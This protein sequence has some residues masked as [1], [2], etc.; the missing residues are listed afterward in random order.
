MKKF[1]ISVALLLLAFVASAQEVERT[2]YTFAHRGEQTLCL[3]LYATPQA[4]SLQPCLVYVFGG[5]FLAGSRAEPTVIEVYEYFARR[6]WK[7]A[8]IDYRLGLKPLVDNPEGDYGVLDIRRMLI[9]AVDMATEDV[10][11]ATAYLVANA[12]QLGVDSGRIVTLG[13]SAGAI[14]VSQAE[15]AICNGQEAA[16][17]LPEGW[18]YAGVISMAGAIL[19]RGRLEWK[20][21]P[22]PMMLFHG[23]ADS[24]VP[25]DKVSLFGVSLHGSEHIYRSLDR[26]DSPCWFYDVRNMGHSYSWRPMY[27]QRSEMEAF[28]ERMAFGGEQLVVRQVV[29]DRSIEPC[30][31]NFW[32]MD[33]MKSNF[34]P[35]NA[36]DPSQA[37]I[38]N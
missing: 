12:E 17:L 30:K 18:N 27:L 24:N 8:A 31:K 36:H 1:F 13:S 20:Q 25:Y 32:L 21:K 26:I 29:D 2:T 9:E 33:Y 3:D 35:D 4:D 14:A 19:E 7:V 28:A 15:Y 16:S 11:E 6:G 37:V 22:C 38:M 10:L 34:S 5:A 23:D